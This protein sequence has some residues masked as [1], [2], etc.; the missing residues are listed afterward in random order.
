MEK[1]VL[2][3]PAG[4]KKKKKIIGRGTGSGHGSTAGRGTKGQKSRAGGGVR[5]GFEGG[6]MPLY[7]RIA[8]RGFSNARFK[9]EYILIKCG[10]LDVF[11]NGTTITR[12]ELVEKNIITKKSLP[13]KVLAG[14]TLTK[15]LSVCLDKVTKGAHAQ[16]TKAGGTVVEKHM[17]PATTSAA[18]PKKHKKPKK[19]VEENGE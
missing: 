18:A 13:V 16:I 15:K 12:K 1:I 14:G 19:K 6:Q 2:K 8:R 11:D 4:A 10:Y 7:R 3:A 17:K 9:K 5:P